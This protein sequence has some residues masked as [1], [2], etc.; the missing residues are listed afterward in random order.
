VSRLAH[1]VR[2]VDNVME[3]TGVRFACL[4]DMKRG[5]QAAMLR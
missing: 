4:A 5:A 2:R 1:L 3:T